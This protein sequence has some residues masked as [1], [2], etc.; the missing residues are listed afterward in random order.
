MNQR[1]VFLTHDRQ[2]PWEEEVP[3][4]DLDGLI[5]IARRQW[6]VAGLCVAVFM[7]LGLGYVLTAVPRYTARTSVLID[8]GNRQV[9]E[10]LS[11]IGGVLDDEASVLSQVEL[12]R[13][14]TIGL[15]AVD[16]LKLQDD[17]EF[18]AGRRNPVLA[19]VSD[20]R[21]I[22]NV[23]RWL[24]GDSQSR[25]DQIEAGRRQ[26]LANLLGNMKVSRVG[27]SYVLEI[28]FTATSPRLAAAVAGAIADAY[29][30]EKLDAKYDATRRAGNWLQ[31]RI[32]EL[33]Q[34]SLE[35]DLAVQ[36]FRAENGLVM[37]NDKLVSDQQLTELNSALIVARADTARA[38]A[39]SERI[40]AIIGTGQ[41]DAIVTD[42]L[43]S[44][45]IS[46]LR[47]KYL[48]ASKREAEISRRLGEGHAQAVRLRQEMVEYNR[49]MFDELR[50]I[51]GSYQSE[52]EV[53]QSRERQIT[54][55]V[56]NATDISVTA[57]ETQV[58]LRELERAAETYRNL[59]QTFLQRYQEAVQQQ[60]FP[61]TEARIISRAVPPTD[62]SE[63]RLS[64]VLALCLALG[65]GVGGAVGAFREFRD[66][67][68]RTGEQVRDVLGLEYLG[69]VPLVELQ[70]GRRPPA[71]PMKGEVYRKNEVSGFAVEHPSSA[72]A[73]T[74]RSARIAADVHIDR[75][76][77]VIGIVSVLPG[78]GKS[79]IAMNFAQ[80]LA[81]SARVL[82]IDADLRNPGATRALGQHAEEGLLEV[83]LEGHAP[84]S[85]M[86][87]DPDTGLRF[88]PAVVRRRIPHSSELLASA[89]M[90]RLLAQV[91]AEFD[92]VVL[93]LPP[94]GPVVDARAVAPRVDGFIM[95]VEWGGTS[96]KAV[97]DTLNAEPQI[98]GRCLGVI[99]NKVDAGKMKLY[100]GYG[101]SD[102]YASRYT[103][104]Y[105]ENPPWPDAGS[106]DAASADRFGPEAAATGMKTRMKEPDNRR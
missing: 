105:H 71:E 81:G 91:A 66:R 86:L 76:H 72:F 15:S 2:Q 38:R 5:A 94:L 98:A 36:R 17:S 83:L 74:L 13:S 95:V 62:A 53:A 87:T 11:T 50:R 73:E 63:P 57:S 12:L 1:A 90:A 31:Q 102:Y 28:S 106:V 35:S 78:E 65:C 59:Y 64:L 29:L 33:R 82:L 99:L 7:V 49:L 58:Q 44:A 93:D 84:A 70:P 16:R 85:A 21:W 45:V 20:I 32:E 25:L 42:A 43:D 27:R 18:M 103:H 60:S 88:L 39:R 75:P 89:A 9:V 46:S 54:Q 61:V 101:S 10:Q 68:F 56:R 69:S 40:D 22:F 47:E 30:T 8:R 23:R 48:E 55:G 51:A 37:A 67:Y 79:T 6:R 52:L 80:A 41:T 100:E 26:A 24:G 77:K 97:K 34:R 19:P 4:L 104:Y 3:E 92:Y 14:E 96:R